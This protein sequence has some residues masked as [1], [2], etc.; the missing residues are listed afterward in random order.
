MTFVATSSRPGASSGME[1]PFGYIEDEEEDGHPDQV[2]DPRLP[3]K[4]IEE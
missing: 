2:D 1:H 3:K 4:R